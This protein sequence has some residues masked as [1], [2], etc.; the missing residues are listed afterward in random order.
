MRGKRKN[1]LII[2]AILLLV[3][4]VGGVVKRKL[5]S[6]YVMDALR[7]SAG[8]LLI[9][10]RTAGHIDSETMQAVFKFHHRASVSPIWF[11]ASGRP[12]DAWGTEFR[13]SRDDQVPP[14]W[15]QCA[16]AGPD[17]SFGTRDDLTARSTF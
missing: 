14:T 8:V 7:T 5:D 10:L 13:F 6:H 17:G 2:V 16:S 3:F 4:A 11:D 15:V 9:E 12:V 1:I